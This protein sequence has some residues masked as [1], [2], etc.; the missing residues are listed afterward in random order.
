MQ[1]DG[2]AGEGFTVTGSSTTTTVDLSTLSID[3][4]V[5]YAVAGT[6]ITVSNAAQG[7]AVTGTSIADTITGSAYADT[8]VAGKGIDTITPGTGN[9]T[10]DLTETLAYQVADTVIIGTAAAAACGVDTIT[11]FKV[12]TDKLSF[13]KTNATANEAA[14]PATF[15]GTAAAVVA[16]AVTV[17]ISADIDTATDTFVELTTTLSSNGTLANA[18]DGSELLKALSSTT[19]SAASITGD[20]AEKYFLAAYQ[21]GDAYIYYVDSGANAVAVASEILLV[22]VLKG[23]AA[24]ALASGDI[25]VHA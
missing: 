1:A 18:I 23:V 14:G 19:T 4:T 6:T 5:E 13:L 12:G 2:T 22:G 3:R 11:G 9:D 21:G 25:L 10:I 16:G 24:G 15:V 20:G 7:V 17:N 8:I